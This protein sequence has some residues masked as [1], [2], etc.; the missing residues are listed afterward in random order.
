MTKKQRTGSWKAKILKNSKELP[1]YGKYGIIEL[2]G[3][4]RALNGSV[5]NNNSTII[6]N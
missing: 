6:S 2:Q 4:G 5:N 1:R 3:T